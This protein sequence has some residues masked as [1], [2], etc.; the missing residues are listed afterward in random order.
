MTQQVT[1]LCK[2]EWSRDDLQALINA[3]QQKEVLWNVRHPGYSK[4]GLRDVALREVVLETAN[5][6]RYLCYA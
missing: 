3:F 4:R 6:R 2:M 5:I 1:S